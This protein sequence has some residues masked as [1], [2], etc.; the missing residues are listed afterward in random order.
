MKNFR[1]SVIV[2]FVSA[3]L[4][5]ASCSMREPAASLAGNDLELHDSVFQKARTEIDRSSDSP[6]G[7]VSLAALYMKE[8]RRIGDFSLNT[9]AQVLVA[10]ALELSPNNIPARKLEAS[11]HLAH[12]RFVEAI[13]AAERLQTD[14]P[15]DS[16]VYGILA[17]AYVEMGEYGKAIDA[18]QKMVDLKPGTAAYSRVAQLRSLHG[19]HR[20]AVEM[21]IQ[22]AKAADPND[23][24]TQS[25]CLVQLGDEYW[26]VG[27]YDDAESVYDEALQNL[28]GYFLATVSKGRLKTSLGDYDAAEQ[29]LTGMPTNANAILFLGDIYR[30][31]GENEKA[32]RQYAQFDAIQARLGTAADHKRLVISWADRGKIEEALEMARNE[33]AS[34]KSIHSADLLA[35]SLYKAG[36]ATDAAKYMDEAMRLKTIDARLLY[37]AGMIA[38]ANGNIKDAK[39]LLNEALTLNPGFDRLC[40]S[41]ARQVLSELG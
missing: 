7:Y 8:A 32:D 13:D 23:K 25:W 26:K 37:H 5:A 17:D 15:S 1:S 19:Y 2:C 31:R 4:L 33:Y 40:A 27:K 24:E 16:F 34:E 36:N 11:L 22:A 20:G 10:K 29:L 3:M 28:P 18:A 9:N 35:W 12:H 21:F 6:V 14:A 38:R 41:E 39:R 30:A